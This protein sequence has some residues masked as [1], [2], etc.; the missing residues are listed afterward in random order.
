MQF[1]SIETLTAQADGDHAI[2]EEV[3]PG[4]VLTRRAVLRFALSGMGMAL[5]GSAGLPACTA[6]SSGGS[7]SRRD[8]TSSAGALARAASADD[9]LARVV[10]LARSLV[11]AAVPDEEAY[12]A[13]VAAM[14]AGVEAPPKWR[15]RP[16]QRPWAMDTIAFYPP[17][18]FMQIEMAPSAVIHLHDHRN[19]NGVLMAVD[20]SVRCRNFD[21]VQGDGRPLDLAAGEVPSKGEEFSIR[22]N[23]DLVLR[24]GMR[25]TLTRVRDNIHHVEAGEQGATLLDFFTH[26]SPEARSH[27]LVWDGKAYDEERKLYRVAWKGA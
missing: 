6:S 24:P 13:T 22:Q 23:A 26:F 10:P 2:G 19:Y 25:S 5:I 17:I 7:V 12:L 16:P 14:L 11:A 9:F 27:E 15:E 20:G 8:E 21:I 18:V 4:A 3:G 1:C